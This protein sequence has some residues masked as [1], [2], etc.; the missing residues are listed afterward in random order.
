MV[1][2][3]GHESPQVV[4]MPGGVRT[5]I[6]LGAEQTGG[7]FCLLV[8]E[9]PAGWALPAHRHLYEAETIHVVSG[10][11]E[12]EVDG[13]GRELGPG[14]TAHIPVATV[15][16]GGNV[17]TEPGRR[18]VMFH[19]G[20]IEAFFR[21]AGASSPEAEIDMRAVVAAA[22]RHGWDFSGAHE[23]G[24]IIRRA[25][26]GERDE[27]L[28]LWSAAYGDADRFPD[29][30]AAVAAL[31]ANPS[32]ALVVATE[33]SHLIGT[34]IAAWDGWRGN[35]YRLAVLPDHRRR[36]VA[37]QLIEAAESRLSHQGAVRVSALVTRNDPAAVATW[38]ACGYTNDLE[39]SRFIKEM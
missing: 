15:H 17:G 20:G 27:I 5:E 14:D 34:V 1:R 37:R 16:S 30:P 33:G 32:S 26:I 6:W 2:L 31:I 4:W 22:V 36:G 19:P 10:R 29:D 8:D 21:E 12:V 23:T 7:A 39:K 24:V 9:P 11:F 38:M 35:I 18:V 3:I 28:A 25:R 13:E